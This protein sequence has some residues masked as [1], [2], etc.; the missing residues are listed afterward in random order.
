MNQILA[1]RIKNKKTKFYIYFSLF[2][3]SISSFL[4]L[5]F[6]MFNYFN[7][8][9]EQENVSE[10][11]LSNYSI[12]KLYYEYSKSEKKENTQD[13]IFGIIEIPKINVYYPVFSELNEELLKIAPCK[14]RGNSPKYNGNIC[15]AGHNYDNS[16]F[17]SNL[18][19]L[20]LG[21][22]IFIYDNLDNIYVYKVYDFY[23]VIESDLSPVFNY[24][25]S[26]KELTLITCNN[27][28]SKRLVVK[29]CQM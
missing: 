28:N 2:L 1:T 29:C 22:E 23:E 8:L 25:K 17:F 26:R 4:A 12:Y 21:D 7:N 6:V 13:N 24:D 5:T 20:E 16:I 15:I 9:K 14:F 3:V 11:I 18:H 27:L 10:S 19:L